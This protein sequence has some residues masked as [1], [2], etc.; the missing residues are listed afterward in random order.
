MAASGL[1]TIDYT[2]AG[3]YLTYQVEKYNLTDRGGFYNLTHEYPTF[4]RDGQNL[5]LGEHAY[6][7]AVLSNFYTMRAFNNMT[8]NASHPG[9]A[10]PVNSSTTHFFAGKLQPLS[11]LYMGQVDAGGNLSFSGA[12]LQTACVGYGGQDIANISNVA[13]HCGL[14]LGPPQ[15]TDGGDARLP[16]DNST[17]TQRM[18]ACASATRARMQRVEFASNGTMDLAALRIARSD[19]ATPVLW[20]MEK[21]DILLSDVD[22][23][24]GR[25]PD[26]HERAASLWTTRSDVFYVPAGAT[27]IWGVTTGGMAGVLPA[28]AWTTLENPLS[29]VDYSG[30]TN[31]A[32]L[33]KFQSML[34]R[35]PLGGAAQIKNLM[36][37]DLM[38][39]NVMG[40]DSRTSLLVGENVPS[41]SY[42][43]RYA[44]PAL[45]L[46]LLWLP[47][48]IGA[49]F[50]LLT[51][52]LNADFVPAVSA[53][54]HVCGPDRAGRLGPAPCAPA[55]YGT[56]HADGGCD[57]R[58]RRD[59]VGEG[60]GAGPCVGGAGRG[61]LWTRKGAGFCGGRYA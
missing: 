10:L 29:Q 13:V 20:G 23:L 33:R 7:G 60:R 37:T 50:V 6:K 51:G 21:S 59:A 2:L 32:L 22:L 49:A 55:I 18:F 19:I 15:R 5:N 8:R 57:A 28:M 24:W 48:V 58:G 11:M 31:F 27:D 14:F 9:R 17:W 34:L 40:S 1:K 46:I 52:A 44:I 4:N 25:V 53:E 47:S 26:A 42:D 36:W 16:A 3:T 39:N 35:D 56:G 43:L 38:A 45:L 12:N 30:V 41:V 61:R 54:P